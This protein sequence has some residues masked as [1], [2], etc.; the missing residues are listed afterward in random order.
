MVNEANV[1]QAGAEKQ[2]KEAQGKVSEFSFLSL[3]H[4]EGFKDSLAPF[5]ILH[6]DFSVSDRC[7]PSRG[8]STQ[9]S[10]VDLDTLFTKP[11]APSTAAVPR[12]QRSA[13]TYR[14]HP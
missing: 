13:Q 5:F 11:P 7:P 8:D 6:Y 12:N 9:N 1:K 2:L 10:G 4:H 3:Q 14:S